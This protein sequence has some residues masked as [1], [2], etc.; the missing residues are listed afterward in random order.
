[1]TFF[2][3]T[4]IVLITVKEKFMKDVIRVGIIGASPSRGWALAAHVPALQSL[5]DF[6]IYAVSTT[7]KHSA[8]RSAQ[9]L[10]ATLAFDNH[11]D[12]LARSEIDLVVIA[13]NVTKHR[14][15]VLAALSAGKRVYCEW[16]LGRNL[17]EA[18]EITALAGRRGLQSIIG[19]QGRFSPA[20]RYLSDLLAEGYIGQLLNTRVAGAAPDDLWNGVLAPEYEITAD[21]SSGNSLLAIPVGHILDMMGFTVGEF[22][23]VASTLVA[24]RGKAILLRDRSIVP[25]PM[26]DQ[27]AFSGTLE[28][29]ALASVH[30]YGGM[31]SGRDFVWELSGTDGTIVLSAD[32]GYPNISD[33]RIEG[34]QRN[35]KI[36]TLSIPNKYQLARSSVPFAATN[37]AALYTQ[38]ALDLAQGTALVPGF[39]LA[40]RRHRLVDA[41]QRS[42]ATGR[43]ESL[44]WSNP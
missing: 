43:R 29:G 24:R 37:V 33:L 18:E 21:P 5:P 14:E 13:V 17:T 39:E 16:P 42:N 32:R 40:V 27:I 35:G 28:N 23:S 22:A 38:Y 10:H 26:H 19:F 20:V 25:M 9:A 44:T 2:R 4:V 15:L 12:L 3:R 1:V 31:S 11:R 8:E 41:I 7:N 34:A 36:E 6:E 30:Y